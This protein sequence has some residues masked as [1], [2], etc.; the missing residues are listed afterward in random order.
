M[1]FNMYIKIFQPVDLILF[2]TVDSLV[3]CTGYW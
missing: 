2:T 1:W 3:M